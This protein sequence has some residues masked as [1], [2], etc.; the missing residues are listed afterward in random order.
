MKQKKQ[1]HQNL[2]FLSFSKLCFPQSG[3]HSQASCHDMVGPK[4]NRYTAFRLQVL[5]GES[6]SAQ[7][8]QQK[9]WDP[10]LVT[11]ILW[12][13]LACSHTPRSESGRRIFLHGKPGFSSQEWGKKMLNVRQVKHRK[14]SG[15]HL[16]TKDSCIHIQSASLSWVHGIIVGHW[17]YISGQSGQRPRP[18]WS[19]QSRRRKSKSLKAEE[20]TVADSVPVILWALSV[21]WT[22]KWTAVRTSDAA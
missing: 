8:M 14:V 1:C 15:T 2:V 13:R 20:I 7:E 21:Y 22:N 17:S 6:F 10:V 4:S 9:T 16:N 12:V 3:L 5:C 11:W 19:L 18:F